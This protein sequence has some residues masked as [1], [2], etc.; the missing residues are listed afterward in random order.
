MSKLYIVPTPIGN[1]EDITLRAIRILK[2]VDLIYAEDTRTSSRLL[3]HFE[4]ST[5]RTSFHKFN[6]HQRLQRA[7]L[8]LE[9][10]KT[11]ALISDAGTPGISDP[12][13]LLIRECIRKGIPVESLPGPTAFI[14]AL[15]NSGIPADRFYFEGFLPV[16]KGRGTRI[17]RLSELPHT[18]VLYESPHRLLKTLE[19][20]STAMG[21][22]RKGCVSREIS[23]I[24]EEHVRDTLGGLIEKFR[25][26]KIRG[27]IVIVVEGKE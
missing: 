27:E 14:P 18:L 3:E 24:Y 9:S 23:K 8:H 26:R 7:L 5:P 20:L 10:G 1:L 11:A 17:K 15:L 25:D 12:G 13:Y 19:Q 6:E 21:P 16:K 2:E 4:I 22:G